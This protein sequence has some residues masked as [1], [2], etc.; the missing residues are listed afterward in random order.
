LL[1]LLGEVLPPAARA[2]FDP[3]GGQPRQF[4]IAAS[5]YHTCALTKISDGGVRCW[6]ANNVGQLGNDTLN[7]STTAVDAVGLSSGVAAVGVGDTFSCALLTNGQ[8]KCWGSN[9]LGQLGNSGVASSATP[10]NVLEAPGGDPLTGVSILS[11]GASHA[12]VVLSTGGAKCW[13]GNAS[14]QLGNGS[15]SN[16]V[17]PTGV[18][19]YSS[20]VKTID[21]GRTHTC[22]VT[23]PDNQA[24]CFGSNYSGQ[25][26]NGTYSNSFIPVQVTGIDNAV[27][28]SAG[29]DFSCARLN[30]RSAV[31][32]GKNAE[33]TLGDGSGV[34]QPEPIGVSV[35]GPDARRISAGFD[36]ACATRASDG[37]VLCWGRGLDG[38]IGD[39]T[40]LQRDSPTSTNAVVKLAIDI[41]TRGSHTCA[42]MGTCSAKCWGANNVGQLGDGTTTSTLTPVAITFCSLVDPTPTPTPTS[43]P[44]ETPTSTPTPLP[45][46]CSSEANCIPD[47][48]LSSP[49]DPKPPTIT[50]AASASKKIVT[51]KLG[52]VRLGVPTALDKREL[53]RKELA[54]FF[55]RSFKNLSDPLKLLDIYFALSIVKAPALTSNSFEA[56]AAMPTKY[57][58]E[59]RKQR[60]TTRLAPGSYV[61]KVTVRLKDKKGRTFAT[62]KTTGQARFTVR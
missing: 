23:T 42:W 16:T 38:Q 54:T 18:F 19:G 22:L 58:V 6:G 31:C 32:W 48:R 4:L 2:D 24:F 55:K 41:S 37:E 45:D 47:T 57:K 5:Q 8:V 1:L 36:H 3:I 12:C 35:I 10:I 39:N 13:G 21:A 52:Q 56:Q 61:A 28:I 46:A 30:T 17:F 50:V 14:G 49:L 40:A 27:E 33:G 25:L 62:G 60:V 9:S 11:V 15:L 43:T 44:P 34:G 51:V 53:L 26:G 29:T 59:T 7:S 20:G